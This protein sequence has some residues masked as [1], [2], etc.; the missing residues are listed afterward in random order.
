MNETDL[1]S[2]ADDNTPYVMG[3]SIEDVIIKLQNTSLT[4]FQ[5]FHDNQMKANPEKYHF[6]CSKDDK[7]NKIVENHKLF[8]S[9]C[10]KLLGIRFDSKLTFDAHINNICRKG[11]LQLNV[12]ARIAPYMDLNKKR[13]LLNAFFMS[14]FNYFQLVWMCHNR[15][16]NNKVNRLH[17][18][19]LC[20]TYSDKRFSFEELLEI[21]SSV[22][23]HD[24]NLRALATEMCKINHNIS[25]II[26]NETF[27]LRHQN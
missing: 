3:N 9:P 25:P 7:V 18:R 10:E 6:I 8:I 12:L 5:W 24:R 11:G 13:Y 15:T 21:D 20:L 22:S 26:M 1:A 4:P 19:C 14:Q 17:E 16:K 27:T 23:V 2:Y